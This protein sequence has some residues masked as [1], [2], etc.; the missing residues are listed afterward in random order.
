MTSFIL[1][2]EPGV[3]HSIE[4]L[5]VGY[6][7]GSMKMTDV[8]RP[9]VELRT[10]DSV[11]GRCAIRVAIKLFDP[12]KVGRLGDAFSFAAPMDSRAN[13]CRVVDSS[14]YG[15]Q[16]R[17]LTAAPDTNGGGRSLRHEK[18]ACPHSRDS[19]SFHAHRPGLATVWHGTIA[20]QGV[21]RDLHLFPL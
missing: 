6:G 2:T 3:E 7:S 4:K 17:H 8:P 21:D 5:T 19:P 14:A 11:S 13:S 20:G 10:C 16:Q 15:V 18:V 9:S 1:N 12:I